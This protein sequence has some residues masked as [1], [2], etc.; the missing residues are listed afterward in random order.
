MGL[1]QDVPPINDRFGL[2]G[3]TFYDDY[4]MF[5]NILVIKSPSREMGDR[6]DAVMAMAYLLGTISL[7][8][9]GDRSSH[10][11]KEHRSGNRTRGRVRHPA[12]QPR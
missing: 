5:L 1:A 6:S 4:C 9:S 8:L 10:R 3:L 12:G 11:C 2:I 7:A